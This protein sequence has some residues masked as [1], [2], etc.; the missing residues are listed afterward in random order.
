M[1]HKEQNINQQKTWLF[2]EENM[3]AYSEVLM[4][5]WKKPLA[6][7]YF[8]LSSYLHR[9]YFLIIVT[10]ENRIPEGSGIQAN[11]EMVTDLNVK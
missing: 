1:L 4:L 11:N 10:C 7:H 9:S 8:R 6:D 3:F 5:L 2:G